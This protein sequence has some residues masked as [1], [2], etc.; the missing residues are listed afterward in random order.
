M[1]EQLIELPT[2]E[3]AHLKGF[4]WVTQWYY[5]PSYGL[6]F[7]AFDL[8]D[9]GECEMQNKNTGGWAKGYHSAPSQSL[10]QKWLRDEHGM[11]LDIRHEGFVNYSFACGKDYSDSIRGYQGYE[12]YEIALEA[13]LIEA[14]ELI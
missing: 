13:G 1:K 14:L 8:E 10:L 9:E 5:H 2:A 12:T 4:D 7:S 3:L 6:N 11:N